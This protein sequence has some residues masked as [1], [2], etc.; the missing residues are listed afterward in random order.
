MY[1]LDCGFRELINESG[2]CKN[3]GVLKETVNEPPKELTLSFE[4]V[5]S[6]LIYR[7]VQEM[8]LIS[9]FLES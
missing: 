5:F 3:H 6:N 9:N 1:C 2:F 7:I 4:V 8:R